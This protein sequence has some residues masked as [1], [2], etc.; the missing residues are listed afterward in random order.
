MGYRK[1]ILVS[2]CLIGEPCRYN[3]KDNLNVKVVEFLKNKDYVQVCPEVL[4][5]LKTPRLPCEIKGNSVVNAQGENLTAAFNLGAEKC[6]GLA[7][8]NHVSLCILKESSPSCGVNS[9][10][11]GTFSKC[12][13]KGMGYTARLLKENGFSVI[14]EKDLK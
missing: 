13:I 5:G 6:L 12:K 11:D 14:S 2:S 8:D 9:I 3:A 4:G 1:M 7:K 10:Y